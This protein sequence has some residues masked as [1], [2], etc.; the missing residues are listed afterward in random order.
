VRQEAPF[1]E[2]G[3]E[4]STRLVVVLP[5]AVGAGGTEP[6]AVEGGLR[7]FKAARAE[8]GGGDGTKAV[9]RDWILHTT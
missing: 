4:W 3:D 9:L 8:G 5:H 6:V 2:K 7:E 1:S